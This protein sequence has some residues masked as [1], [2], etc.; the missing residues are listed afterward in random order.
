MTDF[1]PFNIPLITGGELINLKN[2]I[3]K[4]F[5]DN[6]FY[7]KKCNSWLENNCKVR[8]ALLTTSC[9]HAL[10]MAALL[11][12]TKPGDEIIMPSYTFVSSANAFVLRGAKI[13]FVDIRPDT[14]NLDEK[15][16]EAAINKNTKA[17]VT[18]H[19]AGVSCEMDKILTIA[20]K[21]NLYV[22]ED[23][24]HGLMSEYKGKPLGSMGNIGC[25]SF[26]ETKN[27]QC[28]EGGAILINDD[29]LIE[30]AEIIREKG[31]NRN[32]FINGTVDKYTWV[33]IGSSYVLSELNA[34]FLFAQFENVYDVN[35]KR[36]SL[37]NQYKKN[38]SSLDQL[39]IQTIP[40][41]I[42]HNAHLFYIKLKNIYE[43]QMMTEYLKLHKIQ[44]VFHYI[45]LHHS[46]ECKNYYYFCGSDK[47]T[48]KESERLLRLPLYYDLKISEVDYICD[49]IKDFF[50]D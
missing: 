14:M 18:I 41:E 13:T 28:G 19:Y 50:N 22:I 34:A 48:S 40:R 21:Y 45:P 9:T 5:S 7:S 47:Y 46:K 10:E 20:K 49:K 11:I 42:E 37:Y 4:K 6:G 16:I 26:H 3:H 43:R 12:N 23:A 35:K 25:L 38:L 31:T 24:A 15:K 30:R 44:S 36:L 2:I 32:Q 33:D 17:I 27:Y 8:K 1:I 29:S 39:D